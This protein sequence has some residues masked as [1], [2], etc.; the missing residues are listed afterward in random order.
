M[1]AAYR[2]TNPRSTKHVEVFRSRADALEWLGLCEEVLDSGEVRLSR[3]G[4]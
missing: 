3:R 4:N 2:E 1:F